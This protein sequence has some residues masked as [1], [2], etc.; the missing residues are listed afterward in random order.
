MARVE[1]NFEEGEADG[2]ADALNVIAGLCC[3]SAES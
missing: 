2:S 3:K 1:G